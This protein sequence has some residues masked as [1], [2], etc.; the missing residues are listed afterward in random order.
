M[1]VHSPFRFNYTGM[2]TIMLTFINFPKIILFYYQPSIT[3][4]V[5]CLKTTYQ[6]ENLI[7]LRTKTFLVYTKV[8]N[9]FAILIHTNVTAT[10]IK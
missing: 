6:T 10:A 1:F 5:C 7:I 8:T 3:L 9:V 2:G 4:N